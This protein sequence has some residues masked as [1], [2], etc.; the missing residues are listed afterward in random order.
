MLYTICHNMP[1]IAFGPD[2]VQ[3][4]L[5]ASLARPGGNVTGIQIFAAEL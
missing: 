1:I 2:L 5:A 4:G 3:A